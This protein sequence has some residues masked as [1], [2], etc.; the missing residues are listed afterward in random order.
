MSLVPE[1]ITLDTALKIINAMIRFAKDNQVF[2]GS[3]AVVDEGGHV[4]AFERR[5]IAPVST[6]D[7]AIDKAWTAATMK[8]SGRMLEV[9]TRGEAW[10]LNVK[11]K[12]RLTIIPGAIP[13]IAH[14]RIIGGIGHSGGSAEEDLK[15]SQAGWTAIFR[16]E[17]FKEEVEEK[18][19]KARLIARTVMNIVEERNL[20]PVS[21]AV[22][23]EWGGL[24]LLYRMDGAPYGTLELARDKAWTAAAFRN[25]S[26]DAA[27]FYSNHVNNANWNE[28]V[29]L[30]PGGVPFSTEETFRGAI[31]ISGNEPEIDKGVAVEALK[32]LA[33]K[34][35]E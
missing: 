12:G 13:I 2:P 23:D 25:F 4:V 9:I 17:D 1:R 32:R 29:T 30:V 11:H 24:L 14:G 5:D 10:R 3:Y 20:K 26:E 15:I 8:A 28:R 21:I 34:V 18:L 7:I 31:G 6:A 19:S 27:K 22:L 35:Q 33:I 16:E